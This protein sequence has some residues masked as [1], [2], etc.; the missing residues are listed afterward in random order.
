MNNITIKHNYPLPNLEQVIQILDGDYKFFSKL[1][2]K[3]RF[4]Q[5]PIEDEDRYKTAFVTI[6]GLYEW[7]VLA[8]GL[9]NSPPS[10]QRVMTGILS[11][12][13]QFAM[14]YMQCCNL[15]RQPAGSVEDS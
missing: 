9:K 8:Q 14:G 7:N 11:P 5:I 12:G 4:W 15:Y 3:S 6:E 10:F 2:M 13:R 1:D